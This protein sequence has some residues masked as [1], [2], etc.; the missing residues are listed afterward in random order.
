[1]PPNIEGAAS[2]LARK[3]R[4]VIVPEGAMAANLLGLSQQ[5]PAKI[6]YRSD[7]PSRHIVI[8]NQTIVFRHASPKHQHMVHEASRLTVYALRFL[9]KGN[10]DDQ[11]ITRLRERLT[12]KDRLQLLKDAQYGADWIFEIAQKIARRHGR[13]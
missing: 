9:G 8:G 12:P 1:M 3:Y 5:V 11:V 4:W 10:V 6:I 2:A 7:G 13:G